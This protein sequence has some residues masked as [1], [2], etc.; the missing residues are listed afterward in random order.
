MFE[1]P[2]L[3][4]RYLRSPTVAAAAL[5]AACATPAP[6]PAGEPTI[7]HY[8]PP[9]IIVGTSNAGRFE[10]SGGCIFFRFENRPDRRPSALFAPGTRLSPS[11][12]SI[13]LPGGKSIPFGRRVTIAFESSPNSTGLDSICGDN[14]IQILNLVEKEY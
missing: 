1:A 13:L 3:S 9:G 5:L 11:R 6:R 8:P 10:T 4:C 12:R 2:H 7:R 14:P